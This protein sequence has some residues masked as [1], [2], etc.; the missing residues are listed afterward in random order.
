MYINRMIRRH[1]TYLALAASL[2]L[3]GSCS[4]HEK[5][6]FTAEQL[7]TIPPPVTEGL[8]EASGGFVLAVGG[9]TLTA[10]EVVTPLLEHL[11]PLAENSDFETFRRHAAGQVDDFVVAKISGI[12]LYD[13]AA[14][15]AGDFEEALDKAVE[16]ETRKFVDSFG[17]DYAKA[18]EALEQAGM[19]WTGFRQHQRR[20][21]LSQSYL[22][23]KMPSESVSYRQLVDY[24]EANKDDLFSEEPS[25]TFRLIDMRPQNAE[26]ASPPGGG[27][28]AGP[29]AAG[30]MDRI[31]R[32]EDFAELAG[33]YSS[34]P[35]RN[36]GGL[37]KAINPEN[38]AAPYDALAEAAGIIEPGQVAGP[39]EREGH[40]F[41]MKLEE[42]HPR[43]FE[44]FDSVQ[45]QIEARINLE[46]R[47]EAMDRISGE[48]AEQAGIVNKG[49]FVDFCLGRIYALSR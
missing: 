28:P 8:P 30:I 48:L 44:P 27:G 16:A 21:I 2:L 39:M 32:G 45:R 49:A 29:T 12:L 23:S 18:E 24:Y 3:S 31:S 19:D 43:R 40:I 9:R 42:K 35:R 41:I 5:P 13:L 47:R 38:L 10:D 36:S 17:G 46:R 14:R 22:A 4:D 37:W 7:E 15:Q 1:P 6:R 11:K 26:A 25:I 34:G 20:A 33:K